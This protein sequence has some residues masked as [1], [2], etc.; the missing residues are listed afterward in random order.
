M[1]SWVRLADKSY[2]NGHKVPVFNVRRSKHELGN[3]DY[4]LENPT[5][6]TYDFISEYHKK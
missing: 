6:R 4:P 5:Y 2:K 3:G 1:V